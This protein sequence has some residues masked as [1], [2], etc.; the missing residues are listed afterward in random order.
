MQR[1]KALESGKGKEEGKEK[2]IVN[3][4]MFRFTNVREMNGNEKHNIS[5]LSDGTALRASEE[6]EYALVTCKYGFKRGTI[7]F[8]MIRCVK[9]D[10]YNVPTVGIVERFNSE[11]FQFGDDKSCVLGYYYHRGSMFGGIYWSKGGKHEELLAETEDRWGEGE[12]MEL[13]IDCIKWEVTFYKNGEPLGKPVSIE[14]RDVYYGAVQV[15]RETILQV[16]E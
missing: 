2:E 12:T 8:F 7:G 4:S 11:A 9:A 1:I 16:V 6:C 10:S 15:K 13:K 3:E 5:I 14:E